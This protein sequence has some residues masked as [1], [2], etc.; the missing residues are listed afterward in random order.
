MHKDSLQGYHLFMIHNPERDIASAWRIRRAGGRYHLFVMHSWTKCDWLARFPIE[1]TFV[2]RQVDDSEVA[3]RTMAEAEARGHYL[4]GKH[5][6][7]AGAAAAVGVARP[8]LVFLGRNEP[9]PD[10]PVAVVAHME[11]VRLADCHAN[12]LRCGV[13][14]WGVGN[15]ITYG[16]NP[17][18]APDWA[19]AEEM[20]AAMGPDDRLCLH[21]YWG[22]D[23][24]GAV[25]PDGTDLRWPQEGGRFL[26]CPWHD[27]KILLTE[28]GLDDGVNQHSHHGWHYIAGDNYDVTSRI[29][30]AQI[31]WAEQQW[32][33]DP[34]FVGYVLFTRDYEN[35]E[36][37]PYDI[38]DEPFSGLN[39]QAIIAGFETSVW[40][41][42]STDRWQHII[43]Y[44][45]GRRGLDPHVVAAVVKLESGGRVAAES[46]AG[47]VGLM[48]VMPDTYIA[49]R[50][51]RAVLLNPD[52]NIE[53]GCRVLAEAL[54]NAGG[55]LAWALCYYYGAGGGPNST[56]G[57]TY[58]SA[59]RA[60]WTTLWPGLA[61]PIDVGSTGTF[62]DALLAKIAAIQVIELNPTAAL[63]KVIFHD[64][65]NVTSPEDR[66][67]YGGQTF[68]VQRAES[69]ATGEV[70]GY[71]AP[72]SNYNDVHYEVR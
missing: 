47:A 19:S 30:L 41:D 4:A 49:G 56:D 29:Y 40:G 36:W 53:W 24:P 42:A 52:Q 48:Q 57:R 21:H 10:E 35:N 5:L 72:A 31:A 13:G 62:R 32:R 25:F 51:S 60:A 22:L 6:E 17:Q 3:V 66:M 8:R 7:F 34:R 18:A 63:Q 58:L 23:G 15:Q 67:D 54:E 11:A 28:S 44:R 61:C 33:R 38:A 69:L 2:I 16:G 37:E 1:D 26:Q 68:A 27:V 71:W 65:L 70:R 43:D 39:E 9:Q 50:P 46:G 14:N 45:A 12:G 55:D 20:H 59:F 64:G